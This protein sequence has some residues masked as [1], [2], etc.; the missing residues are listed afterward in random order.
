MIPPPVWTRERLS[1][2]AAKSL[3]ALKD[4]LVAEIVRWRSSFDWHHKEFIR[5]LNQIGPDDPAKLWPAQVADIFAKNLGNAFRY[6]AGPPI[7]A[8]DLRALAGVSL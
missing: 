6:L 4:D 3:A 2:D 5:L 7:S 1:E 8:E